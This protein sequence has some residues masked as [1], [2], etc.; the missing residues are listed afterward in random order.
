[1]DYLFFNVQ[2]D[3]TIDEMLTDNLMDNI[4]LAVAE[5]PTIFRTVMRQLIW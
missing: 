1:M 5:V 2:L 4:L 3:Y